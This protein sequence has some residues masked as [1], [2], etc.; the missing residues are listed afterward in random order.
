MFKYLSLITDIYKYEP[1]ALDIMRSKTKNDPGNV[2]TEKELHEYVLQD[3]KK[4]YPKL[5]MIANQP[6]DH[7]LRTNFAV[8]GAGP[9]DITVLVDIETGRPTPDDI[10]RISFYTKIIKSPS[11]QV[12]LILYAPIFPSKVRELANIADVELVTLPERF[13]I[14]K[15]HS[16]HVKITSVKAWMVIAHILKNK[17]FTIRNTSITSGTSFGWTHAIFVQLQQSGII[18]RQGNVYVLV[19][20]PRLLDGL[21]WERP[22]SS[23]IVKE[24]TAATDTIDETLA[25]ILIADKD[26]VLTGYSAAEGLTDYSRRMDLVQVYSTQPSQLEKQLGTAKE[27]MTIQVLRPDRQIPIRPATGSSKERIPAVSM[28]QLILDLAGL[29]YPARDV[30]MKVL[31]KYMGRTDE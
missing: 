17:R 3:L 16:D 5:R 14:S 18:E 9:N 8:V 21:A 4:R 19:D 7:G 28:D 20:L 22:L 26:A 23:F 30:L 24:W 6:L 2:Q 15:G 25:D 27:G 1:H 11:K 13:L 10:M 29:G 12:K 31:E